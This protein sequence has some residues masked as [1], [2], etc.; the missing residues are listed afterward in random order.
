MGF[1]LAENAARTSYMRLKLVKQSCR[2]WVPCVVA[3]R[4]SLNTCVRTAV[5]QSFSFYSA[6]SFS[7]SYFFNIIYNV[8]RNP[9]YGFL[10]L[11]N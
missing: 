9:F 2:S 10:I 6:T 3:R 4:S 5:P 7:S 8:G 1:K 11:A